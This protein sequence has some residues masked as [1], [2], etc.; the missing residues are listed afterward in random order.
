MRIAVR[1]F[2][3][4]DI[5]DKV[6]WINDPENHRYLHYDLPLTE[7]GTVK[8]FD[9][10]R[11]REDRYDGVITA[12][13]VPCGVIGLLRI[14]A[15]RRDAEFYITLGEPSMRHKGI[16]Q[17]ASRIL[18]EYAFSTLC[19]SCIYLFTEVENIPAQ[20]LFQR[21]GFIKEAFLPQYYPNG[22]DAI[23]FTVTD[24]RQGG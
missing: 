10:V 5:P 8:W 17:A 6:R 13:G 4:S 19:L 16:A 9:R 18:L 14:D 11:E 22:K 21:M 12:D 15:D 1:R 23:R 2:N 20:R 7:E 24:N 3:E